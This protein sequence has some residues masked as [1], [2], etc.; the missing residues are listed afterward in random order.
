MG[1]ICTVCNHPN[2]ANIEAAIVAGTPNRDIACQFN[3]GRMAVQRHAAEHIAQEIKQSQQAKEEV[4]ALDVARQLRE[5][6]TVSL[7]ILQ[8]ARKAKE[9]ELALKA[10]DRV[11]KQLELQAKLLG[12]IDQ[13]QV[14][15]WVSPEWGA[16]RTAIIQALMP[17]QD[18]KIAVAAALA[19]V[20]GNRDSLN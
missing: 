9:N 12:Y 16:I 19:Q 17:F 3:V 2:R 1:R 7:A 6:N 8:E 11:C 13:P 18:A 10:I 20:G 14:N 4:H 5:M 15:I